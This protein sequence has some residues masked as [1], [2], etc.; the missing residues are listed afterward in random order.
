[1]LAGLESAVRDE[2]ALRIERSWAFRPESRAELVVAGIGRARCS[3]PCRGPCRRRL[4]TAARLVQ[5]RRQDRRVTS[6]A[7]EAI[8][9]ALRRLIGRRSTCAEDFRPPRS[10]GRIPTSPPRLL[11]PRERSRGPMSHLLARHGPG[12]G[13]GSFDV[14][15][16]DRPEEYRRLV[17]SSGS[18]ASSSARPAHR[19]GCCGRKRERCGLTASPGLQSLFSTKA[20]WLKRLHGPNRFLRFYGE[21]TMANALEQYLCHRDR[22]GVYRPFESRWLNVAGTNRPR[23]L[24]NADDERRQ[25]ARTP[26]VGASR[27][28]VTGP[29]GRRSAM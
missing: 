19:G 29:R 13:R 3:D 4:A 15:G 28:F 7:E 12:A 6:R 11:A 20:S 2:G 5:R 17:A 1:M 24:H 25:A 18:R 27:A 10:R 23:T 8:G 14:R 22:R 26:R 21:R 9:P 16:A